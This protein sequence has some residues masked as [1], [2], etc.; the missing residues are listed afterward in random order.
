MRR[1]SIIWNICKTIFIVLFT[2]MNRPI[3]PDSRLL[4]LSS[5]LAARA[6]VLH[7]Y[8]TL[9][10]E[11]ARTRPNVRYRYS[12]RTITALQTGLTVPYHWSTHN[13]TIIA[14]AS[15]KT[16]EASGLRVCQDPRCT[17]AK[18]RLLHDFNKE[19]QATATLYISRLDYVA[20]SLYRYDYS[21]L[22]F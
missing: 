6:P 5:R 17:I 18:V 14:R 22:G 7:E 9:A 11:Q 2:G 10:S 13:A 15:L 21:C 12:Y 19:S 4:R 1:V 8:R 20:L 3:Y 16:M